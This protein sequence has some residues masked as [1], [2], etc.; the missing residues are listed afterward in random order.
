MA[1]SPRF[2]VLHRAHSRRSA[3]TLGLSAAVSLV[4]PIAI[5]QEVA[6]V[7]DRDCADFDT[8]RQAQRWFKRHGG[9]RKYDPWNLDSDNDGKAC[10]SLP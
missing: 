10:E 5:T 7:R 1:H 3:L 6:A 9:S 2:T 4:A 8:Q